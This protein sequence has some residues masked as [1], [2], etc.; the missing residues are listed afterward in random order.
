M[1]NAQRDGLRKKR[2]LEHAERIGNVL[3]ACRYFG[4]SRSSFC[5]A[6]FSTPR[7]P[8]MHISAAAPGNG[9]DSR[10]LRL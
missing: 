6:D 5:H 7:S 2:V 1:N 10:D 3:K 4:V 8:I 9:F